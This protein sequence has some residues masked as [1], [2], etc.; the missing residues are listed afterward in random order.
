MSKTCYQPIPRTRRVLASNPSS[1]PAES[2]PATAPPVPAFCIPAP[3]SR[4]VSRAPWQVGVESVHE[5][6]DL[7]M[8]I[9]RED[10]EARADSLFERLKIPLASVMAQANW[11]K[12]QVHRVEVIGGA[13]RI[14]RVKEIAKE[15]FGRSQLDGAINGGCSHAGSAHGWLSTE[16]GRSATAVG[17]AGVCPRVICCKQVERLAEVPYS[18]RLL[19]NPSPFGPTLVRSLAGDEAAAFGSTLYAAKLS[20]SFR[21][22]DFAITDAYPHAISIRL[23]GGAETDKSDDDESDEK[24]TG[25]SKDKLLFKASPA[26]HRITP[27]THALGLVCVLLSAS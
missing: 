24:T 21:L 25:K 12:D 9:K 20:T 6:R 27:H 2:T 3:S 11:T 13:T 15:F 17:G 22:R 26:D 14:L 8:V 7:R 1:R 5:D 10:F 19:V 23:A 16:S 4:A 18:R